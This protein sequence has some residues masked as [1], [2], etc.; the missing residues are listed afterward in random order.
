MGEIMSKRLSFPKAG[1]CMGWVRV[2]LVRLTALAILLGFGV[3][4]RAHLCG[5]PVVELQVGETVDWVIIADLDEE[6]TYYE[7]I[8]IGSPDVAIIDPSTPF[9]AHDGEYTLTGVSAGQTFIVVRWIYEP[10]VARSET[11]SSSSNL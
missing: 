4:A 7:V 1:G 5:P 2:G 10:T 11:L 6:L 8:E 9:E 3:P